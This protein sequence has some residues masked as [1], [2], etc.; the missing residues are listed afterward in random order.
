MLQEC[1]EY[2]RQLSQE[3]ANVVKEEGGANDLVQ[4]IRGH[5]YFNPIL[6]QLEKL[7]DPST[8]VGRAPQQVRVNQ[9]QCF[10]EF[11]IAFIHHNMY[12]HDSVL[13]V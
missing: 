5:S 11:R 2:I 4:R 8:F 13:Y 9:F 10:P 3:A 7:L 1:H 12:L 6:D